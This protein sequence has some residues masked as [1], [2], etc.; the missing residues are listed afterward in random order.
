M[1]EIYDLDLSKSTPGS[2][3][4][5][6]GY[7]LDA[8]QFPNDGRGLE[9]IKAGHEHGMTS[10]WVRYIDG[11]RFLFG[12]GM[13]CQWVPIWRFIDST[14]MAKPSVF[15]TLKHRIYDI[16]PDLYWP[17]NIPGNPISG[18]YIWRDLNNDGNYQ[19]N[20]YVKTK[21]GYNSGFWV[22]YQG[23]IW[24]SN[25]STIWK[26]IPQGLD[27]NGNPIYD[28]EHTVTFNSG[29]AGI[30]KLVYL[31]DRDIMVVNT[32][33]ECRQLGTVTVFGDFSKPSR[34]Q[35]CSF[36]PNGNKNPSCLA[37]AGDYIFT[38]WSWQGGWYW[39]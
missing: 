19:G 26:M 16:K 29:L 12:Q 25:G 2:E 21:Y 28:D 20:E 6:T 18:N 7:T 3:W 11:K 31:E 22:D 17:D 34:T 33:G 35:L 5:L 8:Y 10:A 32:G 36:V 1:Q 4:T 24:S 38:G 15:L 27:E 14:D 37:A 39:L 13:T 23:N 30:N 9:Y